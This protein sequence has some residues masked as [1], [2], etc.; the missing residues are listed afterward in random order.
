MNIWLKVTSSGKTGKSPETK[1]SQR[2][3]HEHCDTR[4]GSASSP[5]TLKAT[6]GEHIHAEKAKPATRRKVFTDKSEFKTAA[7][8][9]GTLMLVN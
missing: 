9:V 6:L 3:Q 8:K 7:A 5:N 4:M 2:P 1:Q